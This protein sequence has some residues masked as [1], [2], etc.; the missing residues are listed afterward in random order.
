ML[1]IITFLSTILLGTTVNS[2]TYQQTI[3]DRYVRADDTAA[4]I[5]T[6]QNLTY[7][8]GWQFEDGIGWVYLGDEIV[9]NSE[10]A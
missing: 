5:D 10:D 6:Q 2:D 3:V 1:A 8:T 9:V 4:L 7:Q